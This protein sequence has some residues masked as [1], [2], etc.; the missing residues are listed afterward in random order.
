MT[1]PLVGVGLY[2]IQEASGLTGIPTQKIR[3]WMYG[4]KASKSGK[5][6]P[7]WTSPVTESVEDSISFQDL[8]EIRFVYAF[9][10][11]GVPL[12]A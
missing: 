4:Y 12:Q 5:Q 3:R 11:H 9:R 1:S 8:L 2:S 7:L 10:K 6:P